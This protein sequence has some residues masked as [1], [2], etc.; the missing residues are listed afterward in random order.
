MTKVGRPTKYNPEMLQKAQKY[1][2]NCQNSDKV[3]YIEEL[4]LKLDI[5]DDTIVE[6]TGHHEEFSATVKKLRLIQK[7]RLK[8]GSL[9]KRLHPATSIFLLKVNHGLDEK[10]PDVSPE[11]VKIVVTYVDPITK[12]EKEKPQN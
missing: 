7:L 10:K 12:E 3:P 6:W 1:V 9:E 8:Q 11:P 2:D 5:N 4:A